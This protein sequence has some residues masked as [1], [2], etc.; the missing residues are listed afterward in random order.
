[1]IHNPTN[2]RQ[3]PWGFGLTVDNVNEALPMGL[4]LVQQVGVPRSSRGIDTIKVP[5]PVST[6]YR[7]PTRRVLFD[8]QRDANPFFHLMESLWILGGS[9]KGD[10]PFHYLARYKDFSD[11]GVTLHG[12]Y[13]A[14]LRAWPNE[15]SWD[16]KIDQLLGVI[17]LLRSKPDS[18]QAVVSIWD[19][20][21][22]LGTVT[23]DMPCNDMVMFA[24]EDGMLDMQVNN[25]SNDVIWGAYGANAVQFSML[26]EIVAIACGVEIGYYVQNSWN[27]HVY[28]SNP[29]W[30]KFLAGEH[31]HGDKVNPYMSADTQPYALATSPADA[32]MFLEDCRFLCDWFESDPALRAPS[33]V[34][35]LPFRTTY[36]NKVVVPTMAAYEAFKDKNWDKAIRWAQEVEANDWSAAMTQW[37][38]RRMVKAQA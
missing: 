12:A 36:F 15:H 18:R 33:K 19:P 13:G 24:I 27:Y 3:G 25:R 21:R 2:L 4:Q 28:P 29:F 16:G 35:A 11:D 26:H 6:I 31:D 32:L 30:Q 7:T 5:G 17:D 10:L 8:E 22:D 1:M 14:R 37:L 20:N 9:N 34:E 23:K 38:V